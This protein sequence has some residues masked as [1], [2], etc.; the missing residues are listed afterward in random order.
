MY[1]IA[2]YREMRVK[3]VHCIHWF[4]LNIATVVPRSGSAA[5]SYST[6]ALLHAVSSLTDGPITEPSLNIK[7]PERL[8]FLHF[9]YVELWA[10]CLRVDAKRRH[11]RAHV[12]PV[13]TAP[14]A[15]HPPRAR[16]PFGYKMGYEATRPAGAVV[17]RA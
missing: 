10:A 5:L 3:C 11:A 12:I 1:G 8:T 4:S 6:G 17:V 2:D 13:N 9:M 7:E 16:S 14:A 15:Q